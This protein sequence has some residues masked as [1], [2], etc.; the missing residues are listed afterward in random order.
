MECTFFLKPQLY[1]LWI[2]K[3]SM[4]NKDSRSVKASI[5][6]RFSAFIGLNLGVE[7]TNRAYLMLKN[8]YFIYHSC[9]LITIIQHSTSQKVWTYNQKF[10]QWPF[11]QQVLR[12]HNWRRWRLLVCILENFNLFVCFNISCRLIH[13]SCINFL[14]LCHDLM[15]TESKFMKIR[16]EDVFTRPIAYCRNTW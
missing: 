15:M 4:G 3:G 14:C 11:L 8:I 9:I 5:M 16:N 13:K 7:S 6:R 1:R 10:Q 12:S 2:L